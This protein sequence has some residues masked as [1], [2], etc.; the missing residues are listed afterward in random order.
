MKEFERLTTG[1]ET[2]V[3]ISILGDNH[4]LFTQRNAVYFI[5]G[6]VI[7]IRQF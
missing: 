1:G 4:S 3:K 2:I 7:S 6:R 5:I